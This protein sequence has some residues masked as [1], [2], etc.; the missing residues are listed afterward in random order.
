M[1]A[2]LRERHNVCYGWVTPGRALQQPGRRRI[3][4][5]PLGFAGPIRLGVVGTKGCVRCIVVAQT[6]RLPVLSLLCVD[7]GLFEGQVMLPK[8]SLTEAFLFRMFSP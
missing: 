1:L 3:Q 8:A 7:D 2:H 6:W 5:N 4:E